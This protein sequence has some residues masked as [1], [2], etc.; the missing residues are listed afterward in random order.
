MEKQVFVLRVGLPQNLLIMYATA[1]EEVGS[2]FITMEHL[3]FY[4]RTI[5]WEIS[6]T[7]FFLVIVLSEQFK[8]VFVKKTLNLEL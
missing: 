6:G 4:R 1:T 3:L 7:A 5:A 2:K 8:I